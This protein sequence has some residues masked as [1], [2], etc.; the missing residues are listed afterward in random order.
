MLEML[1]R[2]VEEVLAGFKSSHEGVLTNEVE[3]ARIPCSG[4]QTNAQHAIVCQFRR[5]PSRL[6]KSSTDYADRRC[7]CC[8]GRDPDASWI[9]LLHIGERWRCRSSEG[10]GVPWRLPQTR[11]PARAAVQDRS[12]PVASAEPWPAPAKSCASRDFKPGTSHISRA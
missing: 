6:W 1:S 12:G 10:S 2:D 11:K 8:D 9:Q 7:D 5:T 3:N 4:G